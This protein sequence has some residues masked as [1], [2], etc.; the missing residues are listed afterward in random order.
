MPDLV[1]FIPIGVLHWYQR[2]YNQAELLAQRIA[3][4]FSLP[5]TAT[6]R[7]R[8]FTPKQSGRRDAAA[9]KKNA[10]RA[11]RVR[12][13]VDLSGKSV[14]LVDDIIT[15]G[16]TVAAAVKL[17]REMGAAHVYVLAPTRTPSGRRD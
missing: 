16:S 2:G 10:E 17:L 3:A 12:A 8:P 9:R 5:C 7:K 4:P 1:T 14:I 15:T 11:L 6:L 13:G